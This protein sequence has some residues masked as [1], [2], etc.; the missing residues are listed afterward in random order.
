M[1]LCI[2]SDLHGNIAALNKMLEREQLNIDCFFFLGDIFGYF[3]GQPVIID[4]LM[5]IKNLWA[6]KGNHDKNYIEILQGNRKKRNELVDKYGSSYLL[7]LT[8]D[9]EEYIRH[10]PNCLEIE[11][12]G[13]L[14]GLF[15][16]G[17]ADFLD[18]R[19]YPNTQMDYS[20]EKY[21]VLLLG[22]THYRLIKKIGKTLIINPG[23]LGQPRDGEGF[24][25]VI[26]DSEDKTYEFKSVVVNTLDLV[27][28]VEKKD[29]GKRV[30][31]YIK[32]KYIGL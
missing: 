3:Y 27:T 5:N 7:S 15:H 9:Q 18:Q 22:H 24:S 29:S 20:I 11:M 32:R 16:G 30:F 31:T 28:Q 10:L 25:Y 12:D 13:Q 1:K 21:D 2:F 26:F 14:F 19:I 6:V 8:Q 17:P 4:K 23:S